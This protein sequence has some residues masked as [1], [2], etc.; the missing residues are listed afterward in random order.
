MK[1][2][3]DPHGNWFKEIIYNKYQILKELKEAYESK[4]LKTWLNL[5]DSCQNEWILT[6]QEKA[7]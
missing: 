6:V 7:V 4:G 2:W 5:Y 3:K 1:H